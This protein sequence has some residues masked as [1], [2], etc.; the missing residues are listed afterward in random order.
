[1]L[2]AGG[3]GDN[4]VKALPEIREGIAKRYIVSVYK[5]QIIFNQTFIFDENRLSLRL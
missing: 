1:M 4:K 5:V 3:S 2:P